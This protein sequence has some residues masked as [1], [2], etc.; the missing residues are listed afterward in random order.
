MPLITSIKMDEALAGELPDGKEMWN[1]FIAQRIEHL[2]TNQ[3]VG[4]SNP[5]EDTARMGHSYPL[6]VNL[7]SQLEGDRA[8]HPFAFMRQMKNT[9][10]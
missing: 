4:G 9:L 6:W 1:V 7:G 3:K 5:S 8:P 2:T 10:V